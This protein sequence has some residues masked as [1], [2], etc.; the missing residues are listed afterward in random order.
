M[1]SAPPNPPFN[2]PSKTTGG[3]DSSERSRPANLNQVRQIN[4][5]LLAW[6][7]LAFVVTGPAVYFWYNYQH[8]LHA[9]DILARARSLQEKEDWLDA[10]KAFHQY[11]RLR[12]KFPKDK[13][14]AREV[15]EALVHRAETFEQV[16]YDPAHGD[17]IQQRTAVSHYI[18]AI[19]AN[20]ERGDLR[21]RQAELLLK[22]YRSAE[23]FEEAE[24]LRNDQKRLTANR[25][26]SEESHEPDGLKLDRL[27]A[28]AYRANIGPGRKFT[29]DKAIRNYESALQAH[30]GDVEL[31]VSL[32]GLCLK[33]AQDKELGDREK[34]DELKKADNLISKMMS[35][36]DAERE[37]LLAR[38]RYLSARL[39]KELTLANS[40]APP[41][42]RDEDLAKLLE[43][44]PNDADVLT[45]AAA[46]QFEKGMN[47]KLQ[48]RLATRNSES[49]DAESLLASSEAHMKS[50]R[51]YAERLMKVAPNNRRS[52]TTAAE[53][54]AR[55]DDIAGALAIL[56]GGLKKFSK[57][58]L[59]LNFRR[60]N[61]YLMSTDSHPV[62]TKA[63]RKM[64]HEIEPV[65]FRVA[66]G[67]PVL[68]RNRLMDD[69]AMAKVR[70][71][72]LE[73]NL[74]IGIPQ[75]KRLTRTATQTQDEQSTLDQ[76][77]RLQLLASAYSRVGL[78]DNAAGEYEKLI[79]IK[80][81]WQYRFQAATEWQASGD[82]ESALRQLDNVIGIH[83]EIAG[84]WLLRA[85]I[86]L[87]QVFRKPVQID[88]QSGKPERSSR[89]WQ[90]F[91][92]DIKQAENRGAAES[93]ILLLKASKELAQGNHESVLGF[94]RELA[95]DKIPA[96]QL[97][98]LAALWQAAGENAEADAVLEQFGKSA[99]NPLRYAFVKSDLL[100][101][102]GDSSA[103]I[104]VLVQALEAATE[105]NQKNTI[106][107][108]LVALEI[109]TGAFQSA[110]DRL[111]RLREAET[112]E[113]WVYEQMADLALVKGDR[114]EV[115]SCAKKLE[116]LD[117]EGV[118]GKYFR[119]IL[120]LDSSKN[121]HATMANVQQLFAQIQ[122]AR[123]SWPAL[124]VLTGFIAGHM[125]KTA[126]SRS[127]NAERAAKFADQKKLDAESAGKLGE[128]ARHKAESA[129]K[130]E[131][132]KQ[133]K[134]QSAAKY[135]EAISHLEH[136][137]STGARSVA[138]LERLMDLLYHENRY[139]EASSYILRRRQNASLTGGSLSQAIPAFIRAQRVGDALRLALA[140]VE[141]K[142]K[143]VGSLVWYAQCLALD[144]QPEKAEEQLLKAVKMAPTEI[145]AWD[146][147]IWFY[148]R[149]R[150]SAD[151]RQALEQLV[152]KVELSA[153]RSE[154]VQAKV[155]T[156]IGDRE[157]AETHYQRALAEDKSDAQLCE[158]VGMFYLSV[159]QEKAFGLFQQA[160][161]IDSKSGSAR[162]MIA[163]IAGLR[164]TNAELARVINILGQGDEGNIADKRRMQAASLLL[165]GGPERCRDAVKLLVELIKS[166]KQPLPGDRLL[167][168]RAYAELKEPAEAQQQYEIVIKAH[169]DP[170]FQI[171][172]ASFLNRFDRL[173][174]SDRWLTQLEKS[175]RD[176]RDV[177]EL[178]CDWL[179]RS[180][181]TPE[182]EALVD[183]FL[184]RQFQTSKDSEQQLALLRYAV[185]IFTVFQLD[186][187]VERKF[188][189]I[190][191]RN[192][193]NYRPLA[194]WLAQHDRAEEALK[195][196]LEER[197][198]VSAAAA[199][200]VLVEV[201]TVVAYKQ[202]DA[203]ID[204]QAAEAAITAVSNSP[205][206][207]SA[208]LFNLGVLRAMQ[209]K[210]DESIATY[211]KILEKDR[212]NAAVMNNLAAV[213]AETNG[214]QAEAVPYI[215]KAVA[216]YPKSLEVLDTKGIV[217]VGIGEFQEARK[218]FESILSSSPEN[219]RAHLHLAMTLKHMGE[220]ELERKHDQLALDKGVER[221]MLT[222][223]ERQYLREAKIS[224]ATKTE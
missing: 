4:L 141:L 120:M 188:R 103:A 136:G 196:C 24:K 107:R 214:R 186:D 90:A 140:A 6:T 95:A 126:E 23:A 78:H 139:E 207:P 182:I 224:A 166:A 91:D 56:E 135:A 93:Q 172:F 220:E 16:A 197:A 9:T 179:K 53:M 184:E 155:L 76:E 26:A 55:N 157:A 130:R 2:A 38:Y 221:E 59:E 112:S 127:Q 163:L 117:K 47:E 146:G 72:M 106:L 178:R 30:P 67:L 75:L 100:N 153:S 217:L 119:V 122:A 165:K 202:A 89:D 83:P 25:S 212:D 36:H 218:I 200:S 131:E 42:T 35:K 77:R 191:S 145:R 152:A 62:D 195:L 74:E 124:D 205:E 84:V 118:L 154:I 68:E 49:S 175:D 61:L 147:L 199:A 48:A 192:P 87:D 132:A 158:E 149:Q 99:E 121:E 86:H 73:G 187:A 114:A 82:L 54:A 180:Q 105:E 222:P 167:L 69:L 22:S 206:P 193:A 79:K 189:E 156:A 209:G 204:T 123:P 63:A 15:A 143:D 208:F 64:I 65:V 148:I 201:M 21:L 101:R 17:P 133:L 109:D 213:L 211:G 60:L 142:P 57:D 18:E 116:K 161:K 128:A 20:P 71:D 164:G 13:K 8:Q 203:N 138:A 185:Q 80:P 198:G 137:V 219:P 92:A 40:P 190:V 125:A 176:K 28:N 12:P 66:P 33:K 44:A 215:E 31:S 129:E 144:N 108:G 169:D 50:S 11:L 10:A 102:R 70:V 162:R 39:D 29:I 1:P 37:S 173:A 14:I 98:R 94:L 171:L 151:V 88:Q 7:L 194:V 104:E 113:L 174:D 32:A 210:N 160:L 170:L 181:R 34:A 115:D 46:S 111:A 96:P 51:E 183:G 45:I 168:A 43:V 58:D 216:A 27:Y 3:S 223:V 159:D 5:R 177:L 97:P 85:E 52:Y 19:R 110:W 41:D 81:V 134:A 150:R